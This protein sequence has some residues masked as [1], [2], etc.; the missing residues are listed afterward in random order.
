MKR[1]V[2]AG[3][4]DFAVPALQAL[5]D[6]AGESYEVVGVY[7]QPDRPAGRGRKLSVSPVKACAETHGIP[8]FQPLNF[9]ETEAVDTL[10]E[11][12]PDLIIVAAYGLLLPEV[13]LNIPRFGCVNLHASILPRWR[14]A[15][16]I[17]RAIEANDPQTGITLMKMDIGL[18][19]GD[20]LAKVFTD[21]SPTETGQSLHDRLA[22]MGAPLLMTHLDTLLDGSLTGDAQYDEDACYAGKLS[23]ADAKL[24]FQQSADILANKVRAMNPW[25]V[26]HA[27]LHDEQA[28]GAKAE[29]TVRIW[30]AHAQ[31]L[32]QPSNSTHPKASI[33]DIINADAD[34][35]SLQVLTANG[36]LHITQLQL[37]G[38]KAVSAKDFLNARRVNGLRFT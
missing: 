7:T 23:K 38:S 20:M 33:G 14:G 13:V 25:P 19:T 37:A 34:R 4:P 21:I 8:I 6:S 16:P 2:Y 31:S 26:C 28:E 5:I 35:D 32:K 24:D 10:S 3:T 18:D 27:Q 30:A 36:V 9:R 12:K 29:Q 1:I 11:L 22:A 15:A 17:Q